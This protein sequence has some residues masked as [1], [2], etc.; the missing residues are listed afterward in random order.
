MPRRKKSTLTPK[1]FGG[2]RGRKSRLS[3]FTYGDLQNELRRR[4]SQLTALMHKRNQMT[5]QLRLIDSQIAAEGGRIPAG[6]GGLPGRRRGRRTGSGAAKG[7]ATPTHGRASRTRGGPSLA[8]ALHKALTGA[9]MSVG[10]VADAVKRAGYQTR[11]PN[12][13]T[14]VNAALLTNPNLFKKVERGVY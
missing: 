3:T 13:R 4:E 14:I 7:M 6:G 9:Q 2:Q 10:Q 12:F 11:S 8:Q 1:F 5:E